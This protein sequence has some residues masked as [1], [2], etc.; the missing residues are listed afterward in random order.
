[1]SLIMLGATAARAV[2]IQDNASYRKDEEVWAWLKS[3]RHWLEV[4][5][6]PTTCR[7]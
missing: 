7:N 4:Y 5:Q 6:L 2:L 1:L 3:N